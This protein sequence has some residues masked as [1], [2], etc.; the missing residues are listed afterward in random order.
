MGMRNDYSNSL[1]KEFEKLMQKIDKLLVE[2]KKQ[3]LTNII[4]PKKRQ[5]PRY[6]TDFIYF[7]TDTIISKSLLSTNSLLID[8]YSIL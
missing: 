7:I 8:F 1:Y 6:K 5:E 2:N 3:S 4:T